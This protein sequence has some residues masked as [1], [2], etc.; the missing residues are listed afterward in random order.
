MTTTSSVSRMTLAEQAQAVYDILSDVYERSP[1]SLEQIS[2]DLAL[3]ST[4][5]F[6]VY[7]QGQVVGF[8]A[9]QNLI[10]E[11]EITNIA[12]LKAYQGRGYAKQLMQCV[13][14]RHEPIFLEVRASNQAAQG[15]YKTSGFKAIGQ[16]KHYYHEP[17]EDA[18][19]MRREGN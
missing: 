9:L 1:W 17:L 3:A 15:L 14:E 16:R 6:Y 12:V 4:D 10:G 7:D 13:A 8:L 19:I 18:I 5:Y 11:L 2:S